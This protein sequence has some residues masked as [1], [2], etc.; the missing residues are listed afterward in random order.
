MLPPPS[1]CCS[2]WIHIHARK[3]KLGSRT[4]M[5]GY[6]CIWGNG[7]WTGKSYFRGELISHLKVTK[8][9][10]REATAHPSQVYLVIHTV[11]TQMYTHKDNMCFLCR[12]TWHGSIPPPP[13]PKL[14]YLRKTTLTWWLIWLW[15]RVC[16]STLL[17]WLEKLLFSQHDGPCK[18]HN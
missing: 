5:R 17:I 11:N 12:E 10:C 4:H 2:K 9:M 15:E 13:L 8:G 18:M 6:M 7:A 3:S 16:D 1:I 14:S